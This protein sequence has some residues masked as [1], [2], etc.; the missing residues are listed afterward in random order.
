MQ[1]NDPWPQPRRNLGQ[2]RCLSFE[3]RPPHHL[4]SLPGTWILDAQNPRS[5]VSTNNAQPDR[6]AERALSEAPPREALAV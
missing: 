3:L 1:G 4:A 5:G 6:G 2:F